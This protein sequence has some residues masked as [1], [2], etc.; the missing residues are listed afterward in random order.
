MTDPNRT[1]E[2]V[3]ATCDKGHPVPLFSTKCPMCGST[4]FVL[5]K[6]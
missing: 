4:R 5:V 1:A 2:R 6:S 3:V